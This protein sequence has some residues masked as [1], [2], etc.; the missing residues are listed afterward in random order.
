MSKISELEKLIYVDMKIPSGRARRALLIDEMSA[1][2]SAK[3]DCFNCNGTCCTFSANSMQVTPIEA[4]E[5]LLSLEITDENVHDLKTRL[6][7]NIGDY[8]L[9]HEIFLGKK[10]HTF[11]RKTYTCPFFTP[12]PK[13]CSIKKDL[14][15]Y[16]CLGFNPKTPGDS[17]SQCLSNIN[18][19]EARENMHQKDEEEINAFLREHLGLN[20]VKLEIPKALL[21]LIEKLGAPL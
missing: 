11:L 16:G 17:G 20:W 10:G 4:F 15:P 19:L 18:L 8:R 6:L 5:I 1:L 7:K 2:S 12:G 3:I 14:K 13:G 21:S 9:E